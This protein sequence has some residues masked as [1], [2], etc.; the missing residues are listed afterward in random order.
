MNHYEEFAIIDPAVFH[1]QFS[2]AHR[3][4][5]YIV[6]PELKPKA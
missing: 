4:L 2:A 5:F 6:N 3:E 1:H